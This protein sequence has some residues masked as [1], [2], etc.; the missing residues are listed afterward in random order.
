VDDEVVGREWVG[1]NGEEVF[2]YHR[3]RVGGGWRIQ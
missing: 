3:R 2:V 1:E